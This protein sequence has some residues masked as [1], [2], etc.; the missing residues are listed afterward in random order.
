[1][2]S[3]YKLQGPKDRKNYKRVLKLSTKDAG[4][5]LQWSFSR[6]SNVKSSLLN[7][8][9]EY[10]LSFPFLKTVHHDGETA[11][12]PSTLVFFL[13]IGLIISFLF[14]GP[15]LPSCMKKSFA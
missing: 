6:A 5:N 15:K 11:T 14:G 7:I 4:D 2:L 13:R 1:M 10:M 3:V 12:T 9:C 8:C